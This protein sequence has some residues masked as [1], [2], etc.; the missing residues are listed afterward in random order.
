MECIQ[1]KFLDFLFELEEISAIYSPE[2]I[3]DDSVAVESL[4]DRRQRRQ[5]HPSRES[6]TH[7]PTIGFRLGDRP[8][9]RAQGQGLREVGSESSPYR[10]RQA[11][12][13]ARR[14]H[15]DDG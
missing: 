11:S 2:E 4:C 15:T 10:S 8:R 3:V 6:F 7:R 14:N 1:R 5:L 9:E 13:E 12:F